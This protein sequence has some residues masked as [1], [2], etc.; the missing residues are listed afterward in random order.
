MLSYLPEIS[1]YGLEKDV[2]DGYLLFISAKMQESSAY[3]EDQCL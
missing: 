3:P 2:I 1:K